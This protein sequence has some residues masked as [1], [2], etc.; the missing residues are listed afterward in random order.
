MATDV[1]KKNVNN[2]DNIKINNQ[3]VKMLSVD[4]LLSSAS[5]TALPI[6]IDFGNLDSVT[7]ILADTR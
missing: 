5:E 3:A 1:E 4:E 6:N 7:E 2:K